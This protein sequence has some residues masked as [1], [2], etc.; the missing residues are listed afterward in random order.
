[1]KPPEIITSNSG[2]RCLVVYYSGNQFDEAIREAERQL[3]VAGEKIG[4]LALPINFR[5]KGVNHEK[6]KSWSTSEIR[7]T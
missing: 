1:M 6:E 7:N 2:A 5:T 4:V 3:G